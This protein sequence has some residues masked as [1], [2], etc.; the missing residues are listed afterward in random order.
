MRFR[1][2]LMAAATTPSGASSFDSN[3]IAWRA[4]VVAAG[5]SVS[6]A[7][8]SL[9]STLIA[10]LKTDS[11]WTKIDNLFLFAAENSQS[12]LIDIKSLR[13]ATS[14]A[15]FT[16]NQ[17]YAGNGSTT[18]VDTTYNPSTMAS[19]Y[20]LNSA[21]VMVYDR[22]ARTDNAAVMSAGGFDGT[23]YAVIFPRYI[24]LSGG[25]LNDATGT[26]AVSPAN[27]SGIW[28][29]S[30]TSSVQSDMYRA[31][32]NVAPGAGTDTSAAVPNISLYVG[33]RNASG[34]LALATTDQH[35]AFGAG[36][37]LNSTEAGNYNTRLQTYMTAVGA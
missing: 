19:S 8:L 1:D 2:I 9:V 31:G 34:S 35:G 29:F 37:G 5:G 18:F 13:Q 3:A 10:G 24:T 7:R 30:R 36:A 4:A 28:I 20:L 27:A 23:N 25:V 14:T 12:A 26:N 16:A 22:T 11:L 32:S 33:G 17:G 21:H 15:T 6:D